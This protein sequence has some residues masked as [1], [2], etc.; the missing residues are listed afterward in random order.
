MEKS[1]NLLNQSGCLSREA[2][3]AWLENRL[4]PGEKIVIEKHLAEC[5]LCREAIEGFESSDPSRV[6]AA[7]ADINTNM[8]QRLLQQERKGLSRRMKLSLA[9]AVLL[10]LIGIFSVFKFRPGEKPIE[11]AQEINQPRLEQKSP[12]IP[13]ENADVIQKKTSENK[14]VATRSF[15]KEKIAVE[16]K[17]SESEVEI[18]PQA[19][20]PVT[21]TLASAGEEQKEEKPAEETDAIAYNAPVAAKK[22]SEPVLA[23]S[24]R[25]AE[26]A[27]AVEYKDK[28]E[29][30][31]YAVQ[32][33]ALFQG[34]DIVKFKTYVEN[35]Y[36]EA[37]KGQAITSSGSLT[38]SFVI[39]KTGKVRDVFVV[40]GLET[41]TDSIVKVIVENSP[42]WQPGRQ[43]G[44]VVN[45][46]MVVE[47][48]VSKKF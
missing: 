44:K 40:K 25:Y 10:M 13:Q 14:P 21:E 45:V 29:S 33:P 32:E 28:A 19:A 41:K 16:D 11:I 35:K 12:A 7:F 18:M 36:V 31:Y 26:K 1:R 38:V 23:R 20:E 39:D 2:V 30:T 37:A 47:V 6:R 43:Q 27:I 9:A 15:S 22:S 48:S 46:N 17:T 42:V 3:L 24:A 4:S 8:Q 34:G 5:T